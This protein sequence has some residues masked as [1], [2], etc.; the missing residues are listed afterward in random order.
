MCIYIHIYKLIFCDLTPNLGPKEQD[1]RTIADFLV[2][3]KRLFM[4]FG[5]RCAS[6][7]WYLMLNTQPA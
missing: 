3:V 1:L 4:I 2:S 7:P 5:K 6:G